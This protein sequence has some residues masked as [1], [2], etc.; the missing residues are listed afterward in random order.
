MQQLEAQA[1]YTASKAG[2]V[3]M[4]LPIARDLMSEGIRVNTDLVNVAEFRDMVI[5]R[6]GDALVRLG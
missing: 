1:A 5:K 3:G 2:I 6:D 4:T